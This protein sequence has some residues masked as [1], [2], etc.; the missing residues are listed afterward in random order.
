[1]IA[2]EA[3]LNRRGRLQIESKQDLRRRGLPSPDFLEAL[4]LT[5]AQGIN[6][7]AFRDNLLASQPGQAI[8]EYNPIDPDGIEKA[9]RRGMR[10]YAPGWSRLRDEA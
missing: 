8:C 1:M 2:V 4:T 5:V 7:E 3:E 6:N 10:Y 9:D